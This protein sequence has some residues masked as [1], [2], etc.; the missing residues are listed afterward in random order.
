MPPPIDDF[1]GLD[2]Q[3]TDQERRLRGAVRAFVQKEIEPIIG[4]AY[5]AGEFPVDLIPKIA[6]MGMLGP[7]LPKEFG[8][9]GLGDVAYG[10]MLQELERGDSGIRS[11]VSVQGALCM[12]PIF[13][14]GSDEQRARWLPSMA[15]GETI[16]CF[17]LTEPDAGSD[18]GSMRTT[19]TRDGDGWVVTGRKTWITNGTLSDISVVWA[20]DED[21]VVRGFVLE[22]GMPGF[23]AREISGKLSLRAS[24]TSELLMDKVPVPEA[25][26]LPGADGLGAPLSCLTQARYGISWGALGAAMGCMEEA[27]SYTKDRVQFGKSLASFQLTQ[28]KFAWMLTEIVKGQLLCL[29]LGR[30]KEGGE[31]THE[32]VSLAKRNNVRF[33][34]ECA[35]EAR[36]MLGGSG[37]LA[38]FTCMRHAQN[39]ES[40]YTYEGAHEVQTLIL[41]RAVTGLDAFS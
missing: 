4:E 22:K 9:V 36:A 16:G 31:M 32:Q 12:Y 37:I 28:A 24:A 23:E 25:N 15:K 30:L 20:K 29:R 6:A 40:V 26:R 10:L 19:A 3:L 39:L 8:G 41:G 35:R 2:D 14:Y 38:D 34:L 21:G 1:Y 5:L 18:P 7:T 13:R 27:L 11:F 33:A 17:G